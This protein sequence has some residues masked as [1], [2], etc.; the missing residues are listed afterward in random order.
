MNIIEREFKR[1]YA[2][3]GRWVKKKVGY[4]TK[5]FCSVCDTQALRYKDDTWPYKDFLSKH[6]PYCG[7]KLR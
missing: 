1:E 6:C 2:K 5:Y 4:D 7:A 3:H